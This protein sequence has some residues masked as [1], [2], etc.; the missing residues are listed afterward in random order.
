MD[1]RAGDLI[2]GGC[3]PAPLAHYLKAIGILRLV[4]EQLDVNAR[5]YWRGDEFRLRTTKTTNE[6]L[7]FFLDKYHPTPAVAPWNAGSGFY[8]REEKSNEVD[9][10]GHR[11]KT[12]KRNVATAATQIVDSVLKSG[13]TRLTDYRAAV[14]AAKNV[15]VGSGLEKAPSEEQKT[16]L[17][18]RARNGLPDSA[19]AWIDAAVVLTSEKP[20]FPPLLGTGGNDGNADFSSNFMQRLS[21]VFDFSEGK[22]TE[23]SPAWLENALFGTPTDGLLR[24]KVSGQF[25]PS[26]TGGTNAEAGFDSKSMIN[27]WDSIFLIEGAL[28]FAASSSKRF[29]SHAKGG[30]AYPFGVKPAGVGYGSASAKDED[31]RP[32]IWLPLWNKPAKATELSVLFSEGRA[33]VGK[34]NA[35]NGVDFARAVAGLGIDRGISAF[36]RYG[37]QERNGMAYFAVPL[38]KF[39]AVRQPQVDLVNEIDGWLREISWKMKTTEEQRAVRNVEEAIIELCRM[40]RAAR[41]QAVL[42]ALGQCEKAIAK[43]AT[44]KEPKDIC[45]PVPLLSPR[46]LKETN[47]GTQEFRIAAALASVYGRYKDKDG[48]VRVVPLRSQLEPVR[49]GQYGPYW[50]KTLEKEVAWTE[51]G[52]LKSMNA[53]LAHRLKRMEQSGYD[54]FSDSSVI[55]VNLPDLVRFLEG[56]IDYGKIESL[57]WGLCL[58]DWSKER[59]EYDIDSCLDNTRLFPGAGF[60]LVKLCFSYV[61]MGEIRV[62]L[63]PEIFRR[64]GSGN[65]GAAIQLAARR[66]R[67]S[68]FKLMASESFSVPKSQQ[69]KAVAALLLPLGNK[70]MEMLAA[71]VATVENEDEGGV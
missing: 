11:K 36:E 68:G 14:L 40:R 55:S 21:D 50:D 8:F 7:D 29:G 3:A 67:A 10:A 26:A 37:F 60:A 49:L 1:A 62:P 43:R 70:E 39:E 64:M 42:V 28:L 24:N 12:G 31:G 32:E 34:R 47:D 61:K 59:A 46:W 33:Q 35:R 38:G 6:L 57:L 2:L 15:V 44:K 48:H 69:D 51:G 22:S 27:P 53:I 25:L 71:R 54:C 4:D 23:L 5:G 63:V 18:I 30:M 16:E 58:I 9:E 52:L 13:T 19:I 17:I 56:R 20:W 65:G 41:M 66:L 45:R